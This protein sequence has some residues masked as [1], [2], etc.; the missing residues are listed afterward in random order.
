MCGALLTDADSGV[1][2]ARRLEQRR[3][4]IDLVDLQVSGYLGEPALRAA[5]CAS[6]YERFTPFADDGWEWT[7][8]PGDPAFDGWVYE[9]VDAQLR[10][11]GVH[12]PCKR[13]RWPDPNWVDPTHHVSEYRVLQLTGTPW[14]AAEGSKLWKEIPR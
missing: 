2:V 10:V 14:T 3:I 4:F 11:I 6:V 5:V 12:L 13:V 9:H 8:H 1:V 7:I